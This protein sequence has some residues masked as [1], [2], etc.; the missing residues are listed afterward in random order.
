VKLL[1]TGFEAWAG[2][3][4]PSGLIAKKLNGRKIGS[5]KVV[6]RELPED[7][8]NL[9]L[10][11]EKMIKEIRPDA[12]ISTGWDYTPAIRVEKVALNV[13]NSVFGEKVVPDNSG[14]RPE[15]EPVINGGDLAYMSTLPASEIV[16][17]LRSAGI[18]A[19]V[20]YH[21]G[22]HCCN[23]TMYSFLHA[24]RSTRSSAIAGFMHLPPIPAMVRTR[25]GI[26]SMSLSSETKA[27]EIAIR[28]CSEHL[29]LRN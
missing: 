10:L 18:P 11:V 8:Y 20:S 25:K 15:A 4:N 27:V 5:L 7:F 17:S 9:P 26:P 6:G 2:Q 1:L 14:N 21:A 16:D 23:T 24:I 13:M 3:V 28:V 12:V 29:R 22:T 19:Y